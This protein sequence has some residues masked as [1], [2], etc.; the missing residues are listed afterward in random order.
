MGKYDIIRKKVIFYKSIFFSIKPLQNNKNNKP[1]QSAEERRRRRQ[2]EEPGDLATFVQTNAF[3]LQ[4]IVEKSGD[5]KRQLLECMNDIAG[6]F[7][8][9]LPRKHNCQELPEV[10]EDKRHTPATIHVSARDTSTGIKRVG[11]VELLEGASRGTGGSFWMSSLALAALVASDGRA[12]ETM[13]GPHRQQGKIVE[14]GCGVGLAGITT[15]LYCPGAQVVLTDGDPAAL[16]TAASNVTR[17]GLAN[18]HVHGEPLAWGTSLQPPAMTS[19]RDCDCILACDCIYRANW[20]DFMATL[21]ATTATRLVLISPSC[22][23]D[24][25]DELLYALA[26]T[27]D[28]VVNDDAVSVRMVPLLSSS[29]AVAAELVLHVVVWSRYT[30]QNA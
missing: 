22:G 26:E 30:T 23:R 9:R 24:G 12:R 29:C 6:D 16:A 27:G 7:H 19:I 1:R 21:L 4:V 14:L 3:S 5:N 18:V 11:C 25:L 2:K 13:F 8:V 17:A 15:A 10:H 20:R 28:F